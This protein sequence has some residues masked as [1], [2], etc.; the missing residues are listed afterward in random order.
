MQPLLVLVTVASFVVAEALRFSDPRHATIA[1]MVGWATFVTLVLAWL[2]KDCGVRA[3]V[4]RLARTTVLTLV[5]F[6]VIY[7]Y[8]RRS[9]LLDAGMEVDASFTF[10][11]LGYFLAF[12]GPI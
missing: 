9:H 3:G 5:A 12:D 10:M 11:G 7:A 4:R 1:S 6:A 8:Y 2:W